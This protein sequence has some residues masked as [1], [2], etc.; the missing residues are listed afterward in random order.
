MSLPFGGHIRQSVGQAQLRQNGT[1]RRR[2]HGFAGHDPHHCLQISP[3]RYIHFYLLSLIIFKAGYDF[4]KA[5]ERLLPN[6]A[7]VA[8]EINVGPVFVRDEFEDWSKAEAQLF[9]EGMQKY[10]KEFLSIRD[11]YLPW[12]TLSSI[13]EFYYLWKTSDRCVERVLFN[14]KRGSL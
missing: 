6:N 3:R 8:G 4:A 9:E 11:D 1:C 5:T 12:K 2:F 10:Q 7:A 14:K 13:I